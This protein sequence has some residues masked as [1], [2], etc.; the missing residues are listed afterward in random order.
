MLAGTQVHQV[1]RS[2]KVIIGKP[3]DPAGRTTKEVTREVEAWIR[4]AITYQKQ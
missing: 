3:I 2:V 4:Q 1:S